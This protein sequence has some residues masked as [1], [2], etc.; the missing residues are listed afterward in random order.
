MPRQRP[1]ARALRAR[2]V[3][4]RE[5]GTAPTAT[6]ARTCT[7]KRSTARRSAARAAQGDGYL[8]WLTMLFLM[9][10]STADAFFSPALEQRRRI[11]AIAVE[12]RARD[13]GDARAS[14]SPSARARR[15]GGST[16]SRCDRARGGLRPVPPPPLAQ[17]VGLPPRFAGVTLARARQ[18]PPDVSATMSAI[19][20]GARYE[21]AGALTGAGMFVG[22][23]VAGV[24]IVSSMAA[25]AR[26]ARARRDHVRARALS[27]C[28]KACRRARG[29]YRG[30][31]AR[32]LAPSDSFDPAPRESRSRA[33][34]LVAL[35]GTR[36]RAS[37]SWSSSW[38]GSSAWRGRG[39]A[40]HVRRVLR[41]SSRMTLR[42]LSALSGT[43]G[44]CSSCSPDRRLPP[45]G[46]AAARCSGRARARGAVGGGVLDDESGKPA[47][48][49]L[50]HDARRR[51]GRR[52]RGR[53][54]AR[55]AHAE[56]LR[57]RRARGG[58]GRAAA[59]R[60]RGQRRR[61][62]GPA[63]RAAA[64]AAARGRGRGARAAAAAAAAAAARATS[65]SRAPRA[66]AAAR[67]RAAARRARSTTTAARRRARRA[68]P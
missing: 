63:R 44:S 33:R 62:R 34:A 21:L 9:L 49:L 18:R 7:R 22:T 60:R 51:Q 11:A 23:V 45:H 25:R 52:A 14:F 37:S 2:S 20:G 38:A 3:P 54:A 58:G 16:L 66:A 5:S 4:V 27:V 24:V 39:P 1:E 42:P 41:S 47:M 67:R 50:A 6:T 17:D 59:A 61:R 65:S 29:A 31:R 55:C 32:A 36:S 46:R 10:G 68:R 40:R 26:R 64:V 48:E 53:A 8:G 43:S 35:A 28:E 19:E 13:F 12:A 30:C 15:R 56:Q 57:P